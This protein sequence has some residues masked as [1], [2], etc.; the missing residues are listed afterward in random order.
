MGDQEFCS[1]SKRV[2][3]KFHS[4]E[5]DGDD[6]YI[7]C[8][9]CGEKRDAITGSVLGRRRLVPAV[10]P[11]ELLRGVLKYWGRDSRDAL[12]AAYIAR[13]ALKRHDEKA[14]NVG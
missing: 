9:W 2:D 14:G 6:P 7:K 11:W 5:F 8:C 4:W 12:T 10:D 13:S 1:A 3:G